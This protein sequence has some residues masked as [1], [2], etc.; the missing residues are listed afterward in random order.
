MYNASM[1]QARPEDQ[2]NIGVFWSVYVC[3]CVYTHMRVYACACICVCVYTHMRVHTYACTHICVYVRVHTY[4]CMRASSIRKHLGSSRVNCSNVDFSSS[5]ASC[6]AAGGGGI[7]SQPSGVAAVA[8][9]S[10]ASCSGGRYGSHGQAI[11]GCLHV[12]ASMRHAI[13]LHI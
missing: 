13:C 2:K 5:S 7:P 4:A 11:F 12:A 6:S 1:L 8:S 3:V 10:S 9:S